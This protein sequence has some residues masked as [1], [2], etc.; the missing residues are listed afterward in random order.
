VH[1]RRPRPAL[2]PGSPAPASLPTRQLPR[3]RSP[4]DLPDCAAR[5][6]AG[7][8]IRPACLELR[9]ENR[10][11]RRKPSDVPRPFLGRSLSR[12][13]LLTEPQNPPKETPKSGNRV[14][15]EEDQLFRRLLPTDPE[16]NPK[17]L[18]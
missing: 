7:L 11:P 13:A 2:D 9:S 10:C 1:T 5:R 14:A 18:P 4:T 3:E 16:K 15:L 12:P 6:F 17:A 8:S